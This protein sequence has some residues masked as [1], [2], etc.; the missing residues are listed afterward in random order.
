MGLIIRQNTCEKC[1]FRELDAL[2]KNPDGSPLYLCHRFPPQQ[3]FVGIAIPV[4]GGAKVDVRRLAAP[5][6]VQ[7]NGWCGEWAPFLE[8]AN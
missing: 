5:P 7:A 4:P 3:T 6:Q 8:N 2:N 1:K